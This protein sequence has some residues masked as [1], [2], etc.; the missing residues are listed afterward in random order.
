MMTAHIAETI[1][2]FVAYTLDRNS[3]LNRDNVD[4]SRVGM[5]GHS[6]GGGA[7]MLVTEQWGSPN[8]PLHIREPK[9]R[10]RGSVAMQPWNCVNG[11]AQ[12]C[13]V[14]WVKPA[15]KRVPA[16]ACIIA[17][18]CTII[19]LAKSRVAWTCFATCTLICSG[20]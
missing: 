15:V 1:E 11:T 14:L 19:C 10:F 7:T 13:P 6:S 20:I 18:F 2:K 16:P 4:I 9:F 17:S 8:H 5:T 3:V 12:P